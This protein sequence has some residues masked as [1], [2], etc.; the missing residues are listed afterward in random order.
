MKRLFQCIIYFLNKKRLIVKGKCI[1][2]PKTQI[3]LSSKLLGRNF[4]S[5]GAIIRKSTLGYASYVGVNSLIQNADIGRYTTISN[6]VQFV[7]GRHPSKK[8]VSIHPVFYSQIMQSG[9]SYVNEQ[10]FEEYR[11]IDKEKKISFKIGNDVWIGHNVCIQEGVT[12]GNGAIVAMGAVVIKDVPDYAIVAGVPAIVI[13][14]R[15][16]DHQIE[17]LK[18]IKWWDWSEEKIKMYAEDF[19]DIDRLME[20][21]REGFHE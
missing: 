6:N 1:I 9:F 13:G 10:K 5:E 3:S 2:E 14:W 11:F 12:I 4:I 8:F 20:K 18:E 7:I 21:Y 15:F 16:D 19:E 17:F